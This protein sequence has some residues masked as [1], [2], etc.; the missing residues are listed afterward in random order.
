[1]VISRRV[2]ILLLIAGVAWCQPQRIIST[3]PSVTEILYALGLG[4]RVV[5]VTTFCHYPPEAMKKTKIGDYVNP[6]LE[7]IASLKPDL[8]IVQTNPV[9]LGERLHA[10]HLHI[11]EIDQQNI[12][13]IYASIR[14]VGDVT[15][16]AG[17]ATRL[18]DSIRGGL[19]AVRVNSAGLKATRVMFVIGRLPNRLDGLT[20]VGNASFLNEVIQIAGGENVFRDAMAAYPRVSLE[21][22]IARSP[23]VILDMGDMSDTAGVTAEH[24]RDVVALWNRVGTVK[25]VREHRVFAIASDIYVVPG[26]RVMDAAREIFGMLHPETR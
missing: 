1:M 7:V 23:D 20:V 16:V 25:A 24:K 12:E 17:N 26:P 15:G 22:V 8:V 2:A 10:L 5:G 21:E 19:D 18:I 3:A 14:R 6:N 11:L 13:A 9:R 4:D